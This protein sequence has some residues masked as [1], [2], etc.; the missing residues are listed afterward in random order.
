MNGHRLDAETSGVILF[1]KTKPALIALANLFG[2][3]R[4]VHH[5]L[6][7]ARGTPRR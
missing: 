4:P 6:A 7:L 1:A 3:E 2:S 5:Y